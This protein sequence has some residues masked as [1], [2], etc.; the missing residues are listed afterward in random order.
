MRRD[1]LFTAGV[2]LLVALAATASHAASQSSVTPAVK[3]DDQETSGD[4]VLVDAARLPDGG[5]IVI[6][7]ERLMDG[8]AQAS[9]I[10]ASGSLT[11][12]YHGDVPVQLDRE[13][14]RSET[15]TAMLHRDT[16]GNQVFDWPDDPRTDHP[17]SIDGDPV[18]DQ[19]TVSPQSS[20]ASPIPAGLALASVGL[21]AV[22][23][24][25]RWA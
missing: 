11:A 12:G 14:D 23:A 18:T 10:G 25:R 22:L 16:N 3:I 1:G 13:I 20:N 19:A 24:A 9:V 4:A 15:L 17:Y 7:D 8:D 6:H 2:V 5:F 21:A